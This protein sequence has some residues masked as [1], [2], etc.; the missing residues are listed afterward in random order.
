MIFAPL[1]ALLLSGATVGQR[2]P[3]IDQCTGDRSF[4]AFRSDLLA[5]IARRDVAAVT[6]AIAET[7]VLGFDGPGGKAGFTAAW[8]ADRARDDKLW[9]ELA[10]VLGAGC[11]V[12]GA[13]RVA[14]SLGAQIDPALD[15]STIVVAANP[16]RLMASPDAASA[17]IKTLDW[18]IVQWLPDGDSGDY[19]KVALGD[20]RSGYLLRDSARSPMD[21]RVTFEKLDGVWKITAFV[22]GD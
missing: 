18:E 6:A 19:L 9:G 16:A 22:A 13:V 8:E 14:P 10:A 11:A 1:A 21:K 2:A 17:V 5:A 12:D 4:T 7:V 20:G 3:P 15:P